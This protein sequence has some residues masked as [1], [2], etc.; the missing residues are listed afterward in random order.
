[1]PSPMHGRLVAKSH[2]TNAHIPLAK[3]A[4]KTGQP[5]QL[6]YQG[7]CFPAGLHCKYLASADEM[8]DCAK[9]QYERLIWQSFCLSLVGLMMYRGS[10]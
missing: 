6:N 7:Y 8:P 3:R 2:T 5:S 9:G 10:F 4:F 1:M